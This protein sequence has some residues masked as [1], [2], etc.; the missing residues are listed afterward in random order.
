[1][2]MFRIKEVSDTRVR[3]V[4]K[5]CYKRGLIGS[6]CDNC[7]GKGWVFKHGHW[8]VQERP[9][10]IVCI[11]RDESGELRYW[12]DDSN[13]YLESQKL[14]HFSRD[15]AAEECKRR[16]NINYTLKIKTLTL[17]NIFECVRQTHSDNYFTGEEIDDMYST[18]QTLIDIEVPKVV[19][20]I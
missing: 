13:H 8:A 1:M 16:N 20:V 7:D 19:E 4:C 5:E 9:I 2:E 3:T 17:E 10:N 14:L 6:Y 11:D 15:D 12:E 18:L